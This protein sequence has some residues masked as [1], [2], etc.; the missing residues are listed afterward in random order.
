MT[1][2][3]Q[4]PHTPTVVIDDLRTFHF[5]ARYLRTSTDA[6]AWLTAHHNDVGTIGQLWLDHDLGGDDTITSV[7]DWLCEQAVWDN[8][9]PVDHIII[10]TSNPPGAAMIERCLCRWYRTSRVDAALYLAT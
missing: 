7:V 9:L 8:P 10:H 2:T 5:D 6:V 3:A 1:A 4:P